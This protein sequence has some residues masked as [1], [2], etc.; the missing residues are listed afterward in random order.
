MIAVLDFVLLILQPAAKGNER[1]IVIGFEIDGREVM[2]DLTLKQIR[3]LRVDRV[4]FTGSEPV[5]LVGAAR[6]NLST[7]TSV[8][9]SAGP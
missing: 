5:L 3:P 7:I 4:D 8:K 2:L 1:Q 6:V 9:A